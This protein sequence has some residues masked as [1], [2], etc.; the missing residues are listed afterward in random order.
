MRRA[1]GRKWVPSGSAP[2]SDRWKEKHGGWEM[3]AGAGTLI[4]I[5][6]R[7]DRAG[8]QRLRRGEEEESSTEKKNQ[9]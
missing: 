5:C 3:T 4:R 1:G 8:G 2:W 6:F 7:G 9:M